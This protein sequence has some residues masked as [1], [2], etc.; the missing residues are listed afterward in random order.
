M[1]GSG[2][3]ALFSFAYIFQMSAYAPSLALPAFLLMLISAAVNL[4][5]AWVRIDYERK[6]LDAGAKLRGMHFSLFTGIQKIKLSGAE[7]RMFARWAGCYRKEAAL[8][9]R[10]PALIRLGPV[11]SKIVEF[12]GLM[13]LYAFAATSGVSVG[14]YLAFYSA[15]GMASTAIM[16][17]AGIVDTISDIKPSLEMV[18]PIL[19]TCPETSDEGKIVSKLKGGVELNHVTF[20]YAPGGP[21]ILRDL[22]L[23]I[24]PNEYVAIVGR[25]GCGKSTLLRLLLGFEK[26]TQGTIL[27]DDMDMKTLDVRSLR[28][29]IGVVLQDGKLFA[30]DIF[31][32]I[33]V[34]APWITKAQAMEAAEKA[35]ILKDIERMPMG[36]GTLISEGSGGI[37]GGQKQRLMIA[38]AIAPKPRILMFDEATSALDNITQK[39]VS[40]SLDSLH[41]TRI[42]I[43]HRLSTIRHCDRILVLED[44]RIAEEGNYDELV[45]LGGRFAELVRRQI[46]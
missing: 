26:P 4:T 34:S 25:T 10:P 14:G 36:L 40:Q 39:Q 19:K 15:Y 7:K 11:I 38:R 13:L 46:L 18:E 5:T 2:L 29:N 23:K 44:G 45:A 30:G 28:Q 12:G 6:S 20:R 43:A 37:S 22:S 21:D 1:L 33:S 42:V 9:Y 8:N 16:K 3:S 41:C 31:A 32:N 17:L 24:K 27:Y 35:G